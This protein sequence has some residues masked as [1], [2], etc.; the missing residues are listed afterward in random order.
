MDSQTKISAW[1]MII[2]VLPFIVV[3]IPKLFGHPVTFPFKVTSCI[4]AI[5]GLLGYCGYQVHFPPECL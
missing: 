4:L 2:S 3:Q 5:I 1:I